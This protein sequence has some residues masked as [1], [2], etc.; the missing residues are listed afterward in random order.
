[1]MALDIGGSS[2]DFSVEFCRVIRDCLC[3]FYAVPLPQHYFGWSGVGWKK[4]PVFLNLLNKTDE[5]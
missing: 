2:A 1:M 5:G 3:P 4:N